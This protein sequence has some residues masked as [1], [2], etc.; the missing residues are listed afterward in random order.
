LTIDEV[1]EEPIIVPYEINSEIPDF[2]FINDEPVS[3]FWFDP[4]II[5]DD[6][7]TNNIPLKT[8]K[9]FIKSALNPFSKGANR[10][11]YYMQ[12]TRASNKDI[13]VKKIYLQK[14]NNKEDFL[15][16]LE[17]MEVQLVA[18]F[19]AEKFNEVTN[20]P[21]QVIK[22]LDVSA[23]Q[24][25]S[26]S[27]TFTGEEFIKGQYIKYTNNCDYVNYN[28]PNIGLFTAFSHWTYE[29]TNGE[30][31]V[32]DLQGVGLELTDPAIHSINIF[33]YGLT[34]FG[35]EGFSDFF[36]NH[37]CGTFCKYLELTERDP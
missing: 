1:H 31:M 2:K 36:S 29:Y 13:M 3:I 11:A 23:Y 14:R 10:L 7:K 6:I 25:S 4:V 16:Y 33:K 21:T 15:R 35:Q 18:K 26:S 9:T 27:D 32:V 24:I 28:V 5:Y 30:L 20:F 12:D 8:S 37:V 22:F 34:N 17:E 19:L